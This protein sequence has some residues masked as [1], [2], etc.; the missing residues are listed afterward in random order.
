GS[1]NQ[2]LPAFV[3]LPDPRGL[4]A[5]GAIHWTSGFLPAAHQGVAFRAGGDPIPDLSTPRD[6]KPEARKASLELLDEMNREY[7]D[8]NPGDS[9]LA[10]RVR[11]YELAAK[12][13]TSVPEAVGF[14]K[15]AAATRKV[16]G[17]ADEP[18]GGVRRH[19][20]AG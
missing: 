12:M 7:R 5:G 20:L 9:T 3:V 6:I 15:E 1:E 11:S 13:Q 2:D 8:A 14:G 4:P 10:A 17:L 18:T 16:Y 19:W